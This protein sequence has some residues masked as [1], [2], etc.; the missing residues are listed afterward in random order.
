MAS[1]ICNECKGK[2][3]VFFQN[4]DGEYD[5]EPCLCIANREMTDECMICGDTGIVCVDREYD[6][7]GHEEWAEPV[8]CDCGQAYPDETKVV[9]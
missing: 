8:F 1:K 5:C 9:E 7:F 6:E 4:A 3:W 2:K